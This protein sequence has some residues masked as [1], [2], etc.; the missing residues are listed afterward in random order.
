MCA[1]RV[2]RICARTQELARPAPLAPVTPCACVCVRVYAR[3]YTHTAER[4]Y[5]HKAG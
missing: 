1:V 2:E 5:P 3:A 4:S